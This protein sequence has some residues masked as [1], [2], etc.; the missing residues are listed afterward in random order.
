MSSWVV[1]F[2]T[3]WMGQV[4]S[5]HEII[6][7]CTPA[8]HEPW[9]RKHRSLEYYFAYLGSG[10][11]PFLWGKA[12]WFVYLASRVHSARC[13]FARSIEWSKETGRVKE[14]KDEHSCRAWL[15]PCDHCSIYHSSSSCVFPRSF[16]GSHWPWRWSLH[17]ADH[18]SSLTNS[19]L[20]ESDK[21]LG[22]APDE[23]TPDRASDTNQALERSAG[24]HKYLGTKRGLWSL[25]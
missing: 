22:A 5:K 20:R 14:R 7:H 6:L 3:F 18:Q 4:K 15:S 8:L 12:C 24:I 21:R 10:P 1:R 13:V 17:R 25:L 16:L 9:S 23:L 11:G 2:L 19:S